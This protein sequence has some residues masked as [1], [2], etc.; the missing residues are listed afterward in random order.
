MLR[1][2]NFEHEPSNY[3]PHSPPKCKPDELLLKEQIFNNDGNCYTGTLLKYTN[4]MKGWQTRLVTIDAFNRRL[5]YYALDDAKR[6]DKG[7]MIPRATLDI[8]NVLVVPSDEDSISFALS[9]SNNEVIKFRATDAKDRQQW[10]DRIRQASS[11]VHPGPLNIAYPQ[12]I[13]RY[14][15]MPLSSA[16][17]SPKRLHRK[18]ERKMSSK[19]NVL[20]RVRSNSF[21]ASSPNKNKDLSFEKSI[22][23]VDNCHKILYDSIDALPTFGLF[24]CTD[25]DIL[26]LKSVSLSTVL[27]L[28]DCLNALRSSRKQTTIAPLPPSLRFYRSLK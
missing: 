22:S 6:S 12:R 24:G 21:D 18:L 25:N 13:S 27:I 16:S 14:P 17:K 7:S 4:V 26:S 20:N 5:I 8:S 28:H 11:T 10:V 2:S 19:A 15:H 3:T 1:D 23:L 9:I